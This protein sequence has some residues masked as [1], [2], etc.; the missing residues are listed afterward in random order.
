MSRDAIFT[1]FLRYKH[2]HLEELETGLDSSLL[3][4][5]RCAFQSR[6]HGSFLRLE[7]PHTT[8]DEA[9]LE[10]FELRLETSLNLRVQLQ[11]EVGYS[12]IDLLILSV[13][14]YLPEHANTIHLSWL[15]S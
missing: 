6:P 2:K 3:S 4:F 1:T 15:N 14:C 11:E 5:R 8:L 13:D 10:N 9:I 7:Y 12:C